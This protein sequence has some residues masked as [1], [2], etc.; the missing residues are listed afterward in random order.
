MIETS[1]NKLVSKTETKNQETEKTLDLIKRLSFLLQNTTEEPDF[2]IITIEES[3]RDL[4]IVIPRI[5]EFIPNKYWWLNE[6]WKN[7]ETPRVFKL[8]QGN[9]IYDF[10]REINS[11]RISIIDNVNEFFTKLLAKYN[12]EV[13]KHLLFDNVQVSN[14]NSGNPMNG[15]VVRGWDAI[16]FYPECFSEGKYRAK[17]KNKFPDTVEHFMGV[18][19]HEYSHLL[20][21]IFVN[22]W[23]KKFDWVNLKQSVE[24]SKNNYKYEECQKPETCM[25]DYA[26]FH[27]K[28]DFCE[29][30]TAFLLCPE[31]LKEISNEKYEFLK[32]IVGDIFLE[33]RTKKEA[34][35]KEHK[36]PQLPDRITV[37]LE[38]SQIR[39]E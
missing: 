34:I 7:K 1:L 29:S 28:E 23:R 20:E 31:K 14:F 16:H 8:S 32:S 9:E 11:E 27:S 12:L 38:K 36:W 6:K 25:S 13:P 19:I 24:L 2:K 30:M 33:T 35:S 5:K 3:K 39:W 21:P 4:R 37:K 26:L 22:E 18:L 10:S 17:E 15:Q